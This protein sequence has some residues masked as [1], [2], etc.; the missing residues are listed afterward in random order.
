MMQG[1]RSLSADPAP[2]MT[3]VVSSGLAKHYTH[4]DLE[5]GIILKIL[6]VDDDA[7]S[8]T[9]ASKTFARFCPEVEVDEAD[10]S[11]FAAT[12]IVGSHRQHEPYQLVCLDYHMPL[13]SGLDTVQLI[14][15]YEAVNRLKP[16][17]FCIISSDDSAQQL[18][19]EQ[20][21]SDPHIRFIIKPLALKHLLHLY[22][23]VQSSKAV[24]TIPAGLRY[25]NA[26][27]ATKQMLS[28]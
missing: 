28:L 27:Q 5:R 7:V 12:L 18:F 19:A 13:M 15:H 24:F 1:W 4:K 26:L 23:F 17:T 11:M 6:V 14:R 10:D 2:V 8:R 25:S 9:V 22:H 21:G 20:F 3:C 16:V